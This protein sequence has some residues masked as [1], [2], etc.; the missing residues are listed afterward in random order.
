MH[1]CTPGISECFIIVGLVWGTF[2]LRLDIKDIHNARKVLD[3]V[4]VC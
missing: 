3:D 2:L 4:G 1:V